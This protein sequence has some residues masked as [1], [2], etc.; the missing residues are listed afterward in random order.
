MSTKL[1]VKHY[2]YEILV[3]FINK[4]IVEDTEHLM[5]PELYYGLFALIEIF[6]NHIHALKY[7]AD[8]THVKHIVRFSRGRQEV[9]CELVEKLDS[10]DS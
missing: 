6:L 7:L 9:F 4:A 8:I 3:F 1:L 5:A 2:L 10:C